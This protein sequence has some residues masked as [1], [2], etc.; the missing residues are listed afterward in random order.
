[1]FKEW[2]EDYRNQCPVCKKY[3]AIEL[4]KVGIKYQYFVCK[5]CGFERKHLIQFA[6]FKHENGKVYL[7]SPKHDFIEV[8]LKKSGKFLQVVPVEKKSLTGTLV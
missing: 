7:K 2:W 4:K 5:F 8:E 3:L 1:M 6:H